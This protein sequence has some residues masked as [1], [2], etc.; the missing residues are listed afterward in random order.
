VSLKPILD[1]SAKKVKDAAFSQFPR[2]HQGRDYMGYAMHTER[3]RYVEWLDAKSGETIARELYDH[4]T[5][6]AEN[7]NIASR[8]EQ[9]E[10]LKALNLQM[11]QTLPRPKLP[12]PFAKPGAKR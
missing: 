12:F 7:V 2:K 11:W 8:P 10:L 3:Y 4:E 5:D 9:A 6:P 1:G